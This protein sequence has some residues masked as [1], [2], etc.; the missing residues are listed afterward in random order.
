MSGAYGANFDLFKCNIS[1]YFNIFFIL[2]HFL[3]AIA[4]DRSL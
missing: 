4:D 3:C 2:D 1:F